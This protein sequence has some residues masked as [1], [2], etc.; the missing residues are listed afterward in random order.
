M[1]SAC[2]E[3]C[4]VLETMRYAGLTVDQWARTRVTL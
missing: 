3:L 1:I 2:Y 4:A